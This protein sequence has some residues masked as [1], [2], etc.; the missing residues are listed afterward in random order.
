MN[1][2]RGPYILNGPKCFCLPLYWS[3]HP[4]RSLTTRGPL[5]GHSWKGCQWLSADTY[6]LNNEHTCMFFL[7]VQCWNLLAH[8]FAES[9][10]DTYFEKLLVSGICHWSLS[11]ILQQIV[12]H[13]RCYFWTDVVWF[14]CWSCWFS[15]CTYY[16]GP[17]SLADP[18]LYLPDFLSVVRNVRSLSP[19]PQGRWSNLS[20]Q[21][22][23]LQSDQWW[24]NRPQCCRCLLTSPAVLWRI[25]TG[26]LTTTKHP[27]LM[28]QRPRSPKTNHPS[29]RLS[30]RPTSKL[31]SKLW[32]CYAYQSK[33]SVLGFCFKPEFLT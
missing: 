12:V 17:S 21:Y 24:V 27:L 4:C 26:H 5:Y 29:D 9:S 20:A 22:I 23:I 19:W 32:K 2:Q 3:P 18:C 11:M 7:G 33:H 6:N 13:S 1:I 31:V 15:T 8:R 14:C 10:R 25:M 16:K 28:V 30:W